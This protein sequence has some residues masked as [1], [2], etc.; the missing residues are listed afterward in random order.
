MKIND[1]FKLTCYCYNECL[2]EYGITDLEFSECTVDGGKYF[3]LFEKLTSERKRRKRLDYCVD[4]DELQNLFLL[5]FY[6][7]KVLKEL[8][9]FYNHLFVYYPYHRIL[10]LLF[11]CL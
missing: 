2:K 9:P 1:V 11:Q 8:G 7:H 3:G 10:V 6:I 4:M 5:I